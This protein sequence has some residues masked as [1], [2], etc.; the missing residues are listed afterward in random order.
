MAGRQD[1]DK[2]AVTTP[3]VEA[4]CF[5]SVVPNPEPPEV[6]LD[7]PTTTWLRPPPDP[8]TPLGPQQPEVP[9]LGANTPRRESV[10]ASESSNQAKSTV[11]PSFLFGK[12]RRRSQHKPSLPA[13]PVPTLFISDSARTL[14]V[15]TG[16]SVHWIARLDLGS[17]LESER[18]ASENVPWQRLW[19]KTT[20]TGSAS[21][22]LVAAGDKSV[23]VVM[24][25]RNVSPTIV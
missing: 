20:L 15:S 12:L 4:D 11:K 17:V 18:A 3:P 23:A 19:L 13:T 10:A 24:S 22:K 25:D 21:V 9:E 1:E 14:L 5:P 7:S 8:G 2:Q 16:P 6:N